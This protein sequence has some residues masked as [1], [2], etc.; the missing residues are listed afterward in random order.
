MNKNPGLIVALI[1]LLVAGVSYF[2]P[3]EVNVAPAPITV[4]AQSSTDHYNP[5]SF[6]ATTTMRGGAN[7]IAGNSTS[8]GI[9]MESNTDGVCYLI[10]LTNTDKVIATSTAGCI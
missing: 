7:F 10:R 3:V 8:T 4:G 1:A 6:Y 9:I 2:R 5:E